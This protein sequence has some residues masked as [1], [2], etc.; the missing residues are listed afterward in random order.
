M[1]SREAVDH[2]VS[3][4]MR[5]LDAG[6]DPDEA[7]AS[8]SVE[9]TRTSPQGLPPL[10]LTVALREAFHE[11]GLAVELSA[12]QA[13]LA[14]PTKESQR[15]ATPRMESE[16]QS[17]LPGQ[18]VDFTDAEPWN[19]PVAGSELL[20][21]IS[22]FIRKFVAVP[23][24]SATALAAWVLATHAV[25]A[26]YIA[27]ILLARS[28][29]KRCGKTLLFDVLALLVYR[30]FK[31][32]QASAAVIFRVL[33]QATPTVFFDEAEA[34]SVRGERAEAMREILNAG[35]RRGQGV[36][37]CVGKEH[38]VRWFNVFGFKAV[39]AIGRLWDTVEDRSI[40]I[41]MRRKRPDDKVRRFRFR[42]VKREAEPL[43][44][45]A[46]R[47]AKDN[48]GLLAEAK[49]DLPDFL[50]DRAQDSWEPLFAIGVAAGDGWY[51]KLVEASKALSTGREDEDQLVL[52]LDD[53]QKILKKLGKDRIASA[54]L[55]NQLA[56]YEDRPWGDWNG[57]N[58]ITERQLARLLKPLQIRPK[59]IR[60]GSRTMR[61]YLRAQFRDAFSRYLARELQHPQQRTPDGQESTS[62]NRNKLPSVADAADGESPGEPGL[63][64]DVADRRRGRK[65]LKHVPASVMKL[66]RQKHR[67]GS[68]A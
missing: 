60:I 18:S 48:I 10:R 59:T 43:R 62:G 40:T 29:M 65:S 25:E 19:Q 47:W 2:V 22:E 34:L 3:A 67:R 52:L 26:F 46:V 56:L 36:P 1:I 14:H 7:M 68:S 63:V 28:P 9:Y 21:R 66:N 17:G 15:D 54:T 16:T 61:G 35:H 37:R 39:A 4:A 42:E 24:Y 49:P 13:T 8:A 5:A 51:E 6:N 50:D 32:V 55:V 41:E 53:L 57:S 31:T 45:M 20:D 27:P 30:P 33:N 23:R 11:R 38:E 44:Q 12:I 58:S 64:A